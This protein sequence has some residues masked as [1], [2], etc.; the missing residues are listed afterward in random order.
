[1]YHLQRL[2]VSEW[3]KRMIM[4]GELMNLKEL[5]WKC[6]DT[7]QG[8]NPICTWSDWQKPWKLWITIADVP[9]K[10]ALLH[11]SV[12]R[13]S[14]SGHSMPLVWIYAQLSNE[15]TTALFLFTFRENDNSMLQLSLC[16]VLNKW[17][18]YAS[19]LCFDSAAV[20]TVFSHSVHVKSQLKWHTTP[21]KLIFTFR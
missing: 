12:V 3:Y 10:H 1:M 2:F 14:C 18:Q 5:A 13:F 11:C 21:L 4:H 16:W 15:Y 8:T 17:T 6:Y 20:D 7:S 9:A 19:A